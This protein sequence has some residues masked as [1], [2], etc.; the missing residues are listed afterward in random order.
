MLEA[1]GAALTWKLSKKR[2]SDKVAA[3]AS[4]S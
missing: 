4:V 1:M 3:V 2:N